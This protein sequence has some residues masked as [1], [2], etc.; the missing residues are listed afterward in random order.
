MGFESNARLGSDNICLVVSWV[1]NG[2]VSILGHDDSVIPVG[3]RFDLFKTKK[4]WSSVYRHDAFITHRE[5]DMI[6]SFGRRL[7]VHQVLAVEELAD[8]YS[9]ISTSIYIEDPGKRSTHIQWCIQPY[10]TKREDNPC[11]GPR[12]ATYHNCL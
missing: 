4:K 6:P 10:S 3:V 5:I 9:R 7:V 1:M 2:R 12:S 11:L 8:I